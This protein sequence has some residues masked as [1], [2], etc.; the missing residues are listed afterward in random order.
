MLDRGC[1]FFLI[2]IGSRISLIIA[3]SSKILLS[4]IFVNCL[5]AFALSFKISAA[6]AYLMY[7][8]NANAMEIVSFKGARLP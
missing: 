1:A 2:S 5:S 4:A 6:F 8:S 7:E 3:S